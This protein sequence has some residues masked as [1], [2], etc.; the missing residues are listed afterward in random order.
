MKILFQKLL[1]KTH[2]CAQLP[3]SCPTLWSHGLV[4]CQAPLSMGFFRQEHWS[5]LPYP[6]PEDL[7][8]PGIKPESSVSSAQKILYCWATG[9]TQNISKLHQKCKKVFLFFNIQFYFCFYLFKICVYLSVFRG[10]SFFF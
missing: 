6:P 5:G 10:V 9:K 3:Q 2:H 7:P 8:D 1:H 4:V